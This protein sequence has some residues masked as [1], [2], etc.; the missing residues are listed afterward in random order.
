MNSKWHAWN[1]CTCS[2][3]E[4]KNLWSKQLWILFQRRVNFIFMFL[5]RVSYSLKC[6]KAIFQLSRRLKSKNFSLGVNY[7]HHIDFS[8]LV[9][10][11][12][13]KKFSLISTY[14]EHLEMC[15]KITFNYCKIAWKF[16][17]CIKN[18]PIW[19]ILYFPRNRHP[20]NQCGTIWKFSKP[21]SFSSL[22]PCLHKRLWVVGKWD[23]PWTK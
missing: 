5:Q 12:A 16:L 1:G 10:L 18:W 3:H 23:C 13:V 14:E 4:E 9:N 20:R 2:T 22:M 21:K 8:K 17:C 6:R 7:G 15:I 19:K 11:C